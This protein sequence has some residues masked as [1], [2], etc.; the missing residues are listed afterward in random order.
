MFVFLSRFWW[1]LVLRGAM[2]IVFGSLAVTLPEP[3]LP[4]LVLVFGGF[5]FSDGIFAVGAASAGRAVTLDRWVLR[6]QGLAGIGIALM[7]LVD[8]NVTAPLLLS[9]IAAWAMVT[10][11]LQIV[12]AIRVRPDYSGEFWLALGGAAGVGFGVLMLLLRE[13]EA[14]ALAALSLIASYAFIWGA[15]LVVGGF[16]LHRTRRAPAL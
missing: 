5:V 12:A 15:L 16:D 10:G 4:A 3:A 13:P 2:A 11:L 9:Y 14:G 8:V 1:V 6:L 7:T